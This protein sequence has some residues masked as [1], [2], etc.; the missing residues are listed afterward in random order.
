[1]IVGSDKKIQR[2][3]VRRSKFLELVLNK[4]DL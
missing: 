3:G 4:D 2:V 1:M